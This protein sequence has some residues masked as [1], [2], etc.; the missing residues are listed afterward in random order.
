MMVIK[1]KVREVIRILEIFDVSNSG[2]YDRKT[3]WNLTNK[4]LYL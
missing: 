1:V 4:F 2:L 3:K